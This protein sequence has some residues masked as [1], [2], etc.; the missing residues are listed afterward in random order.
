MQK[1]HSCFKTIVFPEFLI[2]TIVQEFLA[3]LYIIFEL[4]IP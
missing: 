2:K 1:F 3:I 4:E